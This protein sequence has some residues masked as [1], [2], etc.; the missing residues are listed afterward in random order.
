[1]RL[2]STNVL[3]RAVGRK[4]GKYMISLEVT[5][6]DIEQLEDLA[7]ADLQAYQKETP[8]EYE[9]FRKWGKKTFRVFQHLWKRYDHIGSA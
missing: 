6:Y 3:Q 9:K 4:R 5:D 7:T 2:V 1:M 8:E